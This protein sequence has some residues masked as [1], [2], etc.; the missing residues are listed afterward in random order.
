MQH[1]PTHQT[2]FS[3][4]NKYL[5]SLLQPLILFLLIILSWI[6]ANNTNFIE[7][8]EKVSSIWILITG[9]SITIL[10]LSML[11]HQRDRYLQEHA[12]TLAMTVELQNAK[13]KADQAGKKNE[14]ILNSVSEG[15]FGLDIEGRGI[16]VNHAAAKMLGFQPHELLDQKIHTITHHT[17]SQQTTTDIE[18]CPI[19]RTLNDGKV[20]PR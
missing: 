17:H 11:L 10:S 12:A 1:T 5:P 2:G 8:Q 3:S 20:Q 7:A 16:F 4:L 14:L 13:N 6:F 15:I 18:T 9:I 19:H